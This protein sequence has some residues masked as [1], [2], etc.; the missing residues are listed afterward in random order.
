MHRGSALL[1]R[2]AGQLRSHTYICICCGSE[3]DRRVCPSCLRTSGITE[4]SAIKTAPA[5]P[6]I[7]Q[8]HYCADYHI[9]TTTDTGPAIEDSPLA[10]ALRR[11]KYCDDRRAGRALAD[12][13]ARQTRALELEFDAV[14]PVPLHSNKLKQRGF[15]QSAWL[16]KA[17]ARSAGSRFFPCGLVRRL[18]GKPQ[19]GLNGCER[20]MNLS[21]AFRAQRDFSIYLRVLLVDDVITTGTTLK[22][23]GRALF[24][25]GATDIH[26]AVLLNA[27]GPSQAHETAS[28]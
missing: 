7:K 16:A 28:P 14:V 4:S 10:V 25:A 2:L 27:S 23:A 8:L 21:R 20:R 24:E 5:G 18:S 6:P 15:N 11:F 3:G 26:C 13:M 22:Q 17:V 12:L 9:R 19:C 1:L